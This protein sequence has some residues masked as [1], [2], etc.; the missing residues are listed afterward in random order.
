[1]IKPSIQLQELRRRI[2]L[3]AKADV[4]GRWR[5]KEEGS[6]K[7]D[8]RK[9]HVRFEAAGAGNGF[10]VELVRHRQTKEAETD[11]SH[12]RNTAP[13][14]DPTNLATADTPQLDLETRNK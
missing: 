8:D 7:P 4:V 14:L 2:Y 5:F 1:M 10:T 11:R 13:V 12:L 9:G 3:K 6:G